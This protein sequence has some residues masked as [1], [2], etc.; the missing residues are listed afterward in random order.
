MIGKRAYLGGTFNPIHYG[1]LRMAEEVRQK[2]SLEK[3]VFI[4]SCHPPLKQEDV[5]SAQDRLKMLQLATEDNPYFEVSDIECRR[6]GPSYTIDTI[7]EL[8]RLD[9]QQEILWIIGIDSFLELKLWHRYEELLKETSF[10]IVSR[11]PLSLQDLLKSEYVQELI[12]TNQNF[13]ELRLVSSKKAYYLECT[14]LDIS[15]SQIRQLL[16]RGLSIKY[17]LPQSVESFIISRGLYK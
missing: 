13:S 5:I 1:H 4:L 8:K 6:D 7:K 16:A 3:I 15:S 14:H 11:P 10:V 9:P 2:L 12:E 17:L